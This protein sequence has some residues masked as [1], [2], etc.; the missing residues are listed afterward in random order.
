M[1]IDPKRFYIFDCND[2]MI[3]NLFGYKN[4]SIAQAQTNRTGASIHSKI[5]REFSK[6]RQINPKHNMIYAIKA[7]GVFA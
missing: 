6:A 3:G 5:W 4:H 2:N 7:G 1:Q